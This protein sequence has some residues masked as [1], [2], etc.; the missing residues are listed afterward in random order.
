MR[1]RRGRLDPLPSGESGLRSLGLELAGREDIEAAAVLLARALTVDV[2]AFAPAFEHEAVADH[3][4]GRRLAEVDDAVLLD[5]V[6]QRPDLALAHLVGVD[7]LD[8]RRRERTT[9][10]QVGTRQGKEAPPLRV[11][12]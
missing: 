10:D 9:A 8:D 5:D 1:L 3:A 11:A 7:C 12:P 4:D 6:G 2:D